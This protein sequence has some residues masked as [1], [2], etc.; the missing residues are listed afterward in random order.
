MA[1]E[2]SWAHAARLSG[3][4]SIGARGR[5]AI[6]AYEQRDHAELLPAESRQFKAHPVAWA[7]FLGVAPSN[8]HKMIYLVNSARSWRRASPGS[9]G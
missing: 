6:Y 3:A 2:A 7:V 5:S 1:L 9:G 8:R 4:P